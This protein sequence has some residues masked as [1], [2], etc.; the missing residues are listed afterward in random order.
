M[1]FASHNHHRWVVC[2]REPKH[3]GRHGAVALN[4]GQWLGNRASGSWA[5]AWGEDE[6]TS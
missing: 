4:P 1:C 2:H 3:K 5:V 6:K